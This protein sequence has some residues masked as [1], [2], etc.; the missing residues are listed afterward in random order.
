MGFGKYAPTTAVMDDIEWYHI[1]ISI[2]S[3]TFRQWKRTIDMD[4]G[5]LNKS[6]FYGQMIGI[7]CTNWNYK[8]KQTAK[9]IGIE[10]HSMT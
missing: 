7:R 3:S 6:V 8:C 1:T 2:S 9:S 5:R 10:L 4:E